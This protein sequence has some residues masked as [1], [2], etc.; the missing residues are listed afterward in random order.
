MTRFLF[1]TNPCGTPASA[2]RAWLSERQFSFGC[3]EPQSSDVESPSTLGPPGAHAAPTTVIK[4][5][6]LVLTPGALPAAAF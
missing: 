4:G 3:P 1:V 6:R 2:L 5:W